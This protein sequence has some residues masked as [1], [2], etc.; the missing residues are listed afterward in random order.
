MGKE[1]N[2]G[3]GGKDS[4]NGD[5]GGPVYVELPGGGWR[6]FGITSYGR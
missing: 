2:I 4:C 5:S 1:I 6:V 3:G